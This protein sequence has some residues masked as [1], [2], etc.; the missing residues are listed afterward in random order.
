MS[1]FSVEAVGAR[2]ALAALLGVWFKGADRCMMLLHNYAKLIA[3]WVL[4]VAFAAAATGQSGRRAA[5]TVDDEDVV[6][7]RTEEVLLPISVLD[8]AGR[9]VVGLEEEDFL[10]YDNGVRQQITSF[11][12]RRVPANIVLLLDASGSVFSQMR[13]IRA[14]ARRFVQGLSIEDRVA[15]VQFADRVEVIQE[16]TQDRAAV[17]QA[18]AWRYRPGERT[19]LYDGLR[20]VALD[21]LPR[22]EGRRV[23][24]LLTDGIDTVS[25]TR[26]DEALAALRQVE[27]VVYVI[28]LTE[29]LR[30]EYRL[31]PGAERVVSGAEAFLERV[32]METGGRT[33]YPLGDD[34]LEQAYG[35]IAEELRTQYILTYKPQPRARGWHEVRVLVVPGGYR[36]LTRRGYE[37]R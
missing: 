34:D 18:I 23:V 24:I 16:W 30:R 13:F 37:G 28:S 5:A 25:G 14:A 3:A 21:L 15:V 29:R 12:R 36:V 27:A 2:R 1:S 19:T 11:N 7:V 6:R 26:A 33:I 35:A 20:R 10:V 8:E 32:A 31:A 9:P 17:E 4:V 22:V